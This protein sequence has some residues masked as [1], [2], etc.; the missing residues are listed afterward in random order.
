V[1]VQQADLDLEGGN[2]DSPG[3]G[4]LEDCCSLCSAHPQCECAVFFGQVCYMKASCDQTYEN[5]QRVAVAPNKPPGWHFPHPHP[6]PPPPPDNCGKPPPPPRWP[7]ACGGAAVT[8]PAYVNFRVAPCSIVVHPDVKKERAAKFP[9]FDPKS[10]MLVR[11][12]WIAPLDEGTQTVTASH[13]AS[14]WRQRSDWDR[15]NVYF[16]G[17]WCMSPTVS[18]LVLSLPRGDLVVSVGPAGSGPPTHCYPVRIPAAGTPGK[19]GPDTDGLYMIGDIQP[20]ITEKSQY[21]TPCSIALQL[22][23]FDKWKGSVCAVAYGGDNGYGAIGRWYD[24]GIG[25][26]VEFLGRLCISVIGNHD[27]ENN[28]NPNFC[29]DYARVDLRRVS[30]R[31]RGRAVHGQRDDRTG[32]HE[33]GAGGRV[34]RR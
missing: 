9:D 2:L 20:T 32:V 4:S 11:I 18:T 30:D 34:D 10:H 27:Y 7:S 28:G 6:P 15:K 16:Q 8:D 24:G 31:P 14:G 1:C 25:H 12:S 19:D 33:H 13:A 23:A 21:M 5:P 26:P 17:G 29:S 3:A 22:Q